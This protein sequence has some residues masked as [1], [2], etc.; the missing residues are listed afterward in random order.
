MQPSWS[1]LIS[2]K[3]ATDFKCTSCTNKY[4]PVYNY[5]FYGFY[6]FLTFSNGRHNSKSGSITRRGFRAQI[7]LEETFLPSANEVAERLCF[8]KCVSFCPGRVSVQSWGSTG[9]RSL[10]R[11]GGHHYGGRVGGT[12]PTGMH[13]YCPWIF[14]IR[15]SFN[16]NKNQ[17]CVGR[18]TRMTC[19]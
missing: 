19:G 16:T 10:Y 13:T 15:K 14:D 18:K 17:L 7:P 11:G 8:H 3:N 1:K 4:R 12:H 5:Q 6:G 9:W 2:F